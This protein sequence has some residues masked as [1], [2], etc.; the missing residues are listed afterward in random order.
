MPVAVTT[1]DHNP[2]LSAEAPPP[3]SC[4]LHT[5]THHP[6][7]PPL[8]RSVSSGWTAWSLSSRFRNLPTWG[9]PPHQ[10][11]QVLATFLR[12]MKN[13][14]ETRRGGSEP[15]AQCVNSHDGG[16]QVDSAVH[17]AKFPSSVAKILQKQEVPHHDGE[18]GIRS[19][20]VQK[21]VP[22]NKTL[23]KQK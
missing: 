6:T 14:Q 16:M 18:S 13:R 3:T 1:Q 22:K 19:E 9:A 17:L 4:F 5:H 2:M 15:L 12:G 10:L 20:I 11:Y 8:L 23:C 21:K 7:P